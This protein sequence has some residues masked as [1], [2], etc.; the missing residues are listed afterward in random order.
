[1]SRIAAASAAMSSAPRRA[2][3]G[4]SSATAASRA[5]SVGG[6]GAAP[7]SSPA[8][9]HG[10][11]SSQA[12]ASASAVWGARASSGCSGAGARRHTGTLRRAAS[13]AR[14]TPSSAAAG[15]HGGARSASA[16]SA[17]SGESATRPRA[18][19]RASI[20]PSA[21]RERK[22]K[23]EDRAAGAAVL[24]VDP[25]A[26]RGHDAARN[27]EAEPA[28]LRL[29]GE[30]RLEEA[31]HLLRRNPGA[32]IGDAHHA[33]PCLALLLAGG[34]HLH[35]AARGARLDGVQ[36]DVGEHPPDLPVVDVDG[37]EGLV[38]AQAKRHAPLARLGVEEAHRLA[39]ER[40]E[41]GRL[42]VGRPRARKGEE[43]VDERADARNL[44]ERELAKARAKLLV[45]GPLREELD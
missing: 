13:R 25:A 2:R 23:P 36:H 41:V 32:R 27:E 21:R 39:R 11:P 8:S 12:A 14:R 34:P 44:A 4:T 16:R 37:R 22:P 42:E 43:I 9:S 10:A 20:R 33:P 24:D 15:I 18:S 45:V 26:V 30:E 38:R 6:G 5:A 28:A 35:A 3:G 19:T 31:G 7:G 40:V 17:P 29:G 1:R